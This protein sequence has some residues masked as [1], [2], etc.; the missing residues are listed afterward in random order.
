MINLIC[1]K[2]FY[3]KIVYQKYVKLFDTYF[4]KFTHTNALLNW[5]SILEYKILYITM[6]PLF[7]VLFKIAS[8][9]PRYLFLKTGIYPLFV[10]VKS[11]LEISS[12]D[13]IALKQFPKWQF[14]T[15]VTF[16]VFR[17]FLFRKLRYIDR[18]FGKI[19]KVVKTTK[20]DS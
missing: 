4:Q 10:G 2:I 9:F 13:Q 6:T 15:F 7:R 18:K 11:L 20:S 1:F 8:P 12:L 19:T 16:G 5:K 3:E 14:C 17:H